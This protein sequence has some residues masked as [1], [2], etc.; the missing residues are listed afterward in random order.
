LAVV[1]LVVFQAL[2]Q[3]LAV[4]PVKATEAALVALGLNYSPLAAAVAHPAWHY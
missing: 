3:V 4:S 1:A 2:S